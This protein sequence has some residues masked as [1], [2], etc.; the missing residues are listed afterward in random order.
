MVKALKGDYAEDDM[1]KQQN[2]I[3]ENNLQRLFSIFES[4]RKNGYPFNDEYITL[5][6]NIVIDGQHRAGAIYVLAPEAI[7]PVQHWIFHDNSPINRNIPYL[8]F[9]LTD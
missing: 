2:L 7:I 5:S 6:N 9:E 3:G 4:V 1:H 8:R